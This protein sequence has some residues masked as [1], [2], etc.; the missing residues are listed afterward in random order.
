MS[1]ATLGT[2]REVSEQA[3]IGQVVE[4]LARN[5]P[6][7][8]QEVVA[9]LVNAAHS[10]FDQSKIRDFVPMLVERRAKVQLAKL[11]ADLIDT[12]VIEVG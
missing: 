1:D 9:T 10:R 7:V 6:A 3:L 8:P 5:H 12:P 11:G 4:R 2:V